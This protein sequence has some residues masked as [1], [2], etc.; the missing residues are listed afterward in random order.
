ME[1]CDEYPD[2]TGAPPEVVALY[3]QFKREDAA[4]RRRERY[5]R[6]RTVSLDAREAQDVTSRDDQSVAQYLRIYHR[7]LPAEE[8]RLIVARCDHGMTYRE[9]AEY[10]GCSYHE[11]RHRFDCLRN[12]LQDPKTNQRDARSQAHMKG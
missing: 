4:E 8:R 2:L 7:D 1:H 9:L 10:L 6:K 3:E 11:I 5:W 12:R